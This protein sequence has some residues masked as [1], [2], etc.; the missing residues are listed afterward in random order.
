MDD[1][2]KIFFSPTLKTKLF[3]NKYM[4]FQTKGEQKSRGVFF[5][6]FILKLIKQIFISANRSTRR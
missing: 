5:I 3:L 1:R 6:L 4:R 2:P